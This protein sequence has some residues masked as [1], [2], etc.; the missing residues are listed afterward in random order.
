MAAY[1]VSRRYS[2]RSPIF[3]MFYSGIVK[4]I[5]LFVVA[6]AEAAPKF[7]ELV[8]TEKPFE[9]LSFIF[10][11][12]DNEQCCRKPFRQFNQTIHSTP[13]SGRMLDFESIDGID[14]LV[15]FSEPHRVD[16]SNSGQTCTLT[17][18]FAPGNGREI[19]QRFSLKEFRCSVGCRGKGFVPVYPA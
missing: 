6:K 7:T 19:S 4:L 11:W 1:A 12:G 14:A 17:E 10:T 3:F 13:N 5:Q 16:L 15:V 8:L 2:K 18:C 9:S